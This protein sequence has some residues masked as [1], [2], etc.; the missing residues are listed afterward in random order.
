MTL[1]GT[2]TCPNQSNDGIHRRSNQSRAVPP[3]ELRQFLPLLR[4]P[5]EPT[6]APP[7]L[8]VREWPH[9]TAKTYAMRE[10]LPVGR[11]PRFQFVPHLRVRD[12]VVR[13]WELDGGDDSLP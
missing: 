4:P 13:L 12:H 8:F 3:L 6:R 2:G 7:H 11:F 9:P 1:D 5:L 10:C